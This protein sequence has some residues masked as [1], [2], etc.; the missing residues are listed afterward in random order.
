L[1]TEWLTSPVAW[2][3]P[4]VADFSAALI[5]ESEAMAAAPASERRAVRREMGVRME[6][7]GFGETF[8]PGEA[9]GKNAAASWPASVW[10]GVLGCEWARGPAS[11]GAHA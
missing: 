5:R 4:A 3:P 1:Q 9:F 2:L 6:V 8:G 11:L 7:N 10:G